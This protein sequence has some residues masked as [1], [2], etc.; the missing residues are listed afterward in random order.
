MSPKS[1]NQ[2]IHFS[3][4]GSL[5][6]IINF[7]EKQG[8]SV[9]KHLRQAG[10]SDDLMANSEWPIPKRLQWKFVTACCK[11]D[12]IEYIGLLVGIEGSV[13]DLGEFGEFLLDSGTVGDYLTKGCRFIN[14]M[15]SGE[16]YWLMEEG[17]Q[18]RFCV[19]IFG[20]QGNHLIQNYLY[21]LLLTINVIRQAT[22]ESW[23]PTELILPHMKAGTAA[24][25]AE[26]LPETEISA[27]GIYAS[28][29]VPYAFLEKPMTQRSIPVDVPHE[30][31]PPD[32]KT[33]V[34]ETIKILIFSR[35]T[36]LQDT[37]K[38]SGLSSRTFQRK[39]KKLGVT[40]TDL[41][42]EARMDVARQWIENS[43]L[44]IT[45]ISKALGYRS[46]SNFSR[47]FRGLVGQSPSAYQNQ[48]KIKTT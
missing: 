35:R 10:I 32:F 18:L 47:A 24:R 7:F 46:P 37:V 17:D 41:L 39:L 42:L 30:S 9:Q 38:L 34:I 5:Q 3:R 12:D 13:E 15:S 1:S 33:S 22:N 36:G 27:D 8:L 4:L 14:T 29:L 25:L 19:S 43:D 21:I 28:F 31:I 48:S 23:C 20:L 44:S 6:P 45:D 2:K 11:A 16:Y 26:Y 40:Y